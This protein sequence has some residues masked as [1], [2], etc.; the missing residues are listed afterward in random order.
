MPPTPLGSTRPSPTAFVRSVQ[1]LESATEILEKEYE[2]IQALKVEVS[3]MKSFKSK[4]L[5]EE[6]KS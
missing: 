3:A 4:E 2:V 1:G 6:M 5:T